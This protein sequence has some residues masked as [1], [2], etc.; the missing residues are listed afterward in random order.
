[1]FI[2]YIKATVDDDNSSHLINRV[3]SYAKHMNNSLIE[4][5]S[6]LITGASSGIG[7][8]LALEYSCTGIHLA[9]CGRNSDRLHEI[10]MLCRAKGAIVLFKVIDIQNQFEMA[11]WIAQIDRHTP[12]DLVIANAGVS[13]GTDINVTEEEQ[14]RDI[15]QLIC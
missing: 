11:N 6:I 12:L 5:K 3:V 7:W 2:Y 8:A 10:S 13:I 1:M 15:S 4:P 14:I 9:L